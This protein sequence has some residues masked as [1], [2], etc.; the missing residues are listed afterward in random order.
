MDVCC[1][2]SLAQVAMFNLGRYPQLI[3]VLEVLRQAGANPYLKNDQG[4]DD[5]QF[6]N[7]LAYNGFFSKEAFSKVKSLFCGW[8]DFD[9][10][11]FSHIHQVVL[12]IRPLQLSDELR[13]S[14]YASQINSRDY[15]GRTPL[16]LAA[17]REGI[18]LRL[19]LPLFNKCSEGK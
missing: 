17:L 8:S 19:V 3:R 14:Q 6:M 13:K 15:L 4:E 10:F 2:F 12:G 1:G 9:A 18:F 16:T 7:N 5:F 11:E